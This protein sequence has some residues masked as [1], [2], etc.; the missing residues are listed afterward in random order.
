MQ[1][2]TTH[3]SFNQ[4]C[5]S[6]KTISHR[7]AAAPGPEVRRECL[8]HNFRLC[9]SSQQ[10]LAT[11]LHLAC[12]LTDRSGPIFAASTVI[13]PLNC[14]YGGCSSAPSILTQETTTLF[15]AKSNKLVA[16]PLVVC[17]LLHYCS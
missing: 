15:G 16:F 9:P 10:I 4:Y 2:S 7:A 14:V 5:I 3:S 1:M 8:W 11:P 17:H 13:R 12:L 6:H